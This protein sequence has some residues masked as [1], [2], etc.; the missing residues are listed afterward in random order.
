M[1]SHPQTPVVLLVEDEWMLR[2]TITTEFLNAGWHVLETASGEGALALL[3]VGQRID[4]L[5]TDI[6]LAGYLNGWDIAEAFR[7]VNPNI[8]V[9]YQSG[10]SVDMSRQ[11]SGSCFFSKPCGPD[12]LLEICNRFVRVV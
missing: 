3:Q 2:A 7:A 12:K 4:V 10:N 11:V 1:N 5:I 6:H 8:P 9:I